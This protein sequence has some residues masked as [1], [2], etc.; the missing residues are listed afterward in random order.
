VAASRL[1]A[2]A[3]RLYAATAMHVSTSLVRTL[4]ADFGSA[5]C[6][7]IRIVAL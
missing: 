4:Y 7:I 5:V 2:F 3:G 6:S 1:M